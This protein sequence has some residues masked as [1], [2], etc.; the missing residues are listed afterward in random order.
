[1]HSRATLKSEEMRRGHDPGGRGEMRETVCKA[2]RR[3]ENK[4]NRR[5]VEMVR[6]MMTMRGERDSCGQGGEEGSVHGDV[7]SIV[8][9]RHHHLMRKIEQ[10]KTK[11]VWYA[12]AEARERRG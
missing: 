2:E 11:N 4:D 6:E 1:M 8:R 9:S 7:F 5:E 3:G 10:N 12:N